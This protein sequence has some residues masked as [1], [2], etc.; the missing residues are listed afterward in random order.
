V[1]NLIKKSITGL[2][3]AFGLCAHASAM[4]I[5]DLYGDKDGLGIGVTDGA[6]FDFNN[7]LADDAADIGTITDQWTTGTQTWTH[8]YDL[9]GLGPIISAG[10][11]IFTGGQGLAGQSS[12]FL[13]NQFIGLLTDGQ[14]GA[15]ATTENIG[16]LD[17]YDLSSFITLLNGA[18]RLRIETVSTADA[19]ALDYSELT[20]ETA[21]VPEPTIIS[22]VALGLLGMGFSRMQRESQSF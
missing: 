10:L 13:D 16:R 4:I 19:W 7:V 2:V 22:L 5:T 17:T 11:E 6:T 15:G 20:I 9:T 21:S 12:L 14:T 18:D 8:T 3:V 1:R